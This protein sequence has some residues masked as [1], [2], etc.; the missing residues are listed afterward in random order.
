LIALAACPASL[1]DMRGAVRRMAKSLRV[2]LACLAFVLAF[3]VSSG[4]DVG[5]RPV[6]AAFARPS[7]AASRLSHVTRSVVPARVETPS[8]APRA[9]FAVP[10]PTPTARRIERAA[11]DRRRLYLEKLSLLC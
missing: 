3:P 9:T 1:I 5:A 11:P 7:V 10:T 4:A 2:L 6:A 8:I